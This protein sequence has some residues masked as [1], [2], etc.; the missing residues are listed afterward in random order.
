MGGY[1]SSYYPE[2]APK[3]RRDWIPD[4]RSPTDSR[5]LIQ[6]TK[7]T[8]KADLSAHLQNLPEQPA[9]SAATLKMQCGAAYAVCMAYSILLRTSKDKQASP[10]AQDGASAGF[11]YWHARELEGLD[12]ASQDVGCSIRSCIVAMNRYGMVPNGDFALK[13]YGVFRDPYWL[14]EVAKSA[15]KVCYCRLTKEPKAVLQALQNDH[16][17][18]MGYLLHENMVESEESAEPDKEKGFKYIVQSA[19]D[20]SDTRGGYVGVIYAFDR[21]TREFSVYGT[22]FPNKSTFRVNWDDLRGPCFGDFWCLKD[23]QS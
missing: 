6:N 7:Y 8:L 20:G 22:P 5:Q 15:H 14:K 2:G 9:N 19:N 21:S 16:P 17:V 12:P 4:I 11:L 3:Y 23:S 18:I 13:D 10:I 1:W